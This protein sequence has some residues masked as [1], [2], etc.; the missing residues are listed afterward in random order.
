MNFNFQLFTLL[1]FGGGIITAILAAVIWNRRPAPG[2]IPLTFFLLLVSALLITSAFEHAGVSMDTRLVW[3]K[4]QYICLNGIGLSWL[5]FAIDYTSTHRLRHRRLPF[6]LGLIPSA[7][8]ILAWTNEYHQLIWKGMNLLTPELGMMTDWR[9]GLFYVIGLLYQTTL[10]MWGIFLIQRYAKRKTHIYQVQLTLFAVGTTFPVIGLIFEILH[11]R[12]VGMIDITP[13]FIFLSSIFYSVAVLRFRFMDVLPV[14]YKALVR[15]IPDGIMILDESGLIMEINPAA[16]DILSKKLADTQGRLLADIWPEL[17]QIVHNNEDIPYAEITQVCRESQLYLAAS[18]VNLKD[19]DGSTA[20]KLVSLRN[21]TDL[22]NSLA[23]E[24]HLRAS[25]EEE[26]QKRSKYSHAI[27]HELRTPL[28]AIKLSGELLEEQ[29]KENIQVS[30]VQNIQRATVNLEQRVNEM[31]ELARGESGLIKIEPEPLDMV[32]IINEIINEMKPAASGQ[33]VTLKAEIHDSRI[34]VMGDKSRIRQIL[35]NL[36]GNSLKFT[37]SGTIT[38]RTTAG[39]MDYF[40]VEV[41]DTGCGMD[42]EQTRT[43]FDPYSR[44]TTSGGSKTGLGIGLTLA[45]MFVQLHGGEIHAESTPGKGTL[46]KFTLPYA[47]ETSKKESARE[48]CYH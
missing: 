33:N 29:V 18:M 43:L 42:E 48:A 15:N 39:S 11:I 24:H 31:F 5:Y 10:L 25:L 3:M 38:I 21:I 9:P 32:K 12:P 22:K 23:Q 27:V 45:K 7:V 30:L 35:M 44:K 41:E 4:I 20:G 13:F 17:D 8:I 2:I 34:T 28:T 40:T 46:I 26:M 37:K 14:A 36:I 47:R 19:R 1:F 16:E 6:L